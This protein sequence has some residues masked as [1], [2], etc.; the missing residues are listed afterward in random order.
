MAPKPGVIPLRP[1][2]AGEILDGAFTSIRRNPKATIGL[3]A[4]LMLIYGVI[5]GAA[6]DLAYQD[7]R[8]LNLQTGQPIS[9][10]QVRHYLAAL[11]PAYGL[12]LLLTFLISELLT[13]MLTVVIGR[14]VLGQR[15]GIGTAWRTALPRLPA[16]F[17]AACLY[18]LIILGIWVGYGIIGV[19]VA[20]AHAPVGLIVAYFV[21]VGIAAVCAT[22][23]LIISYSLAI[24]A[25]VLERQGPAKAL[26]RSWRLVRGSWWRVFGIALLAALIVGIAALILEVPFNLIASVAG[27]GGGGFSFFGRAQDVTTLGIV[28]ATVGSIAAGA[29][30]RPI[31]AGVNVL[32]YVDLRMRKEGLDL[33]LQTAARGDYPEGDEFAA[34]WRPPAEGT[35]MPRPPYAPPPDTGPGYPY[36]G[37]PGPGSPGGPWQ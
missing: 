2:G 9:G 29:V 1:I 16:I 3:A 20:V 18:G 6:Y 13:G 15:I 7:V 37:P 11:V 17:G 23:W 31:G 26:G 35:P 24:P 21:I 12:S 4:I 34:A 36:P 32:L 28:I 19:I 27:G 10:E 8:A 25:V 5:S 22:I 30:T 33:A 14:G